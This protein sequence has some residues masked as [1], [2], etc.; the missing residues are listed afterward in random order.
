MWGSTK[1]FLKP[2]N[3]KYSEFSYEFLKRSVTVVA[4]TTCGL[5]KMSNR[6]FFKPFQCSNFIQIPS[7]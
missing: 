1:G 4:F 7:K 5:V 6:A 2:P 3:V